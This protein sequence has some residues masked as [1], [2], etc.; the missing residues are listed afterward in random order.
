MTG[1]FGAPP[2]AGGPH[3]GP[4]ADYLASQTGQQQSGAGI[5]VTAIMLLI[6]AWN[7]NTQTLVNLVAQLALTVNGDVIGPLP[8]PLD[9][10]STHLT[11]PL[12]LAQGGTGNATGSPS[13]PAGGVLAGN[14]PNPTFAQPS[15]AGSYLTAA[16]LVDFNVANNDWQF[17]IVFPAGTTR[18][19]VLFAQIY[20][21][22][23]SLTTATVGLFS[24]A[25]GTGVAIIAGGTAVTV[26]TGADATNN[27]FQSILGNG[28][29]SFTVPTLY[30]RVGTP[31]GSA[32]TALVVLN[33]IFLP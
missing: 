15:V 22:S 10:V 26:S 25:G 32:A 20:E 12:P 28:T 17:P 24:G 27:N 3:R 30:F 21:A 16:E 1:R 29:T 19:R 8:G 5:D 18:Y 33:I 9:V 4:L 23:A 11:A 31:E 2:G 6:E 14:Y 13:G 7:Q